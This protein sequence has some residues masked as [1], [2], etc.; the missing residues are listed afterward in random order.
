LTKGYRSK[1]LLNEQ[2]SK[3]DYEI[4]LNG[5]DLTSGIYYYQV[6]MNNFKDAKKMIVIK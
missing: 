5:S 6:Q 4:A 1:T 2:H 3:G